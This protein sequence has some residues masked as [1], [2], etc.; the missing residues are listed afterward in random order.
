MIAGVGVDI[1]SIARFGK[2][3]DRAG[4]LEQILTK[5]EL[6]RAPEGNGRDAF[7]AKIFATKEA[8][9][10]ALGCGLQSGFGWHDISVAEGPEVHLSG[11]VRRLTEKQCITRI[12]VSQSSSLSHAVAFV[13]FE[14]NNPEVTP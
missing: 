2:Q 7:F 13:L 5:E 8:V 6:Q 1:V 11:W 9:L 3:K 10:K 12:H 4:F 14:T